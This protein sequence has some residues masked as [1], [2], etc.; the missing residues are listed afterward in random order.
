MTY[1]F[2][3]I[4]KLTAILI[5]KPIT[6]AIIKPII[7][8]NQKVVGPTDCKMDISRLIKATN[9]LVAP[10]PIPKRTKSSGW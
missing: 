8:V 6:R 1:L 2:R 3:G 4:K 9:I 7:I 5:R 10:S